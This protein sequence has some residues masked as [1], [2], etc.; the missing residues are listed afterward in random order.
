MMDLFAGLLAIA[1]PAL[2]VGFIVL[3]R[4]R[5]VFLMYIA[6][7]VL[8]LGYLAVTGAVSDIGKQALAFVEKS[9]SPAPQMAPKA[10]PSGLAAPQ[11][12]AAPPVE[13]PTEAATAA[14]ATAETV[15]AGP[16][17]DAAPAPSP[18]AQPAAPV[19]AP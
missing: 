2:I 16:A 15:P 1:V 11:P 10:Q 12:A 6:A 14:P 17:A 18:E 4:T 7:M 8:G 19:P 5:P 3:G 9:G 13:T